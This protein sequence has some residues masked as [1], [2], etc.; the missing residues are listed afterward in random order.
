LNSPRSALTTRGR[1]SLERFLVSL[2]VL[3]GLMPRIAPA[4]DATPRWFSLPE[5]DAAETLERFAEQ[6]G[7]AVVF[8]VDEVRGLRTRAVEGQLTVADALARLTAGSGLHAKTDRPTAIVVKRDPAA[9]F[10]APSETIVSMKTD[11]NPSPIRRT[12]RSTI[13]VLSGLLALLLPALPAASAATTSTGSI[14]GR[15]MNVASGDFLSR[16]RVTV[17]G[18]AAE[19]YTDDRGEYRLT[20]VPAGR[21]EVRVNFTGFAEQARSVEVSSGQVVRADFR[22][23]APS[24][25]GTPATGEEVVQLDAFT[26]VD[27]ELTAQAVALHEQRSAPNIKSVVAADEFGDLGVT[28]PANF[29]AYMPGTAV[30]IAT[31]EAETVS[32]R[33]M[34]AGTT[35]VMMDGA[36]LAT[37]DFNSRQFSFSGTSAAVVERIEVTKVPTPDVPANAVGGSINMV[38][39]S[40]LS[41]TTPLLRYDVFV[42]AQGKGDVPRINGGFGKEEGPDGKSSA[43]FVRPGFDLNYLHPVNRHLALTFNLAY[44]SRSQDREYISPSWNRVQNFQTNGSLNSVLNIFVKSLVAAGA[45]YRIGDSTFTFRADFTQHDSITRQNLFTY[46]FGGGATGGEFFTRSAATA[47][48]MLGQTLGQNVNQYRKQVNLRAGHR[49]E[50]DRWKF[51]WNASYSMAQRDYSDVDEDMFGTVAI[52]YPNLVLEGQGLDAIYSMGIP[53]L[54][55]RTAAGVEVDPYDFSKYTLNTASSGRQF[56]QSTVKAAGA[57]V[58]RLFRGIVPLTVK[59]GAAVERMSRDAWTESLTWNIRPPAAAGGQV[60][61]NY[62]IMA[63]GYSARRQ[64]H[65]VPP[66][67]WVSAA[68][69]YDLYRAHPEYFQLNETTAHTGR[70][71]SSKLLYETISAGYLRADAKALNNRLWLVGGARYERTVDEGYGP[72]NDIRATFQRDANDN[73]VL[74][75]GRPVPITTDPVQSAKLQFQERA[76]HSKKRWDDI[77]PSLNTSFWLTDALVIRAAYAATMGRPDIA[78]IVPGTSITDPSAVSRTITVVNTGLEPWTADNYDLTLES[79]E[80]KGATVALSGF[81]KELT[82]FFKS[83]RLPASQELLERYSLPD[84]LLDGNYD[85]LFQENST[86]PGVVS[87]LEW[88]WRQSLR[89]FAKLPAFVRPVQFFANGTH[90]RLSGPGAASLAGYSPRVFNWGVGYVASRFSVKVNVS[91]S[92]GT[93][94]AISAPNNTTPAGTY[95]GVGPRTLASLAAEY[96]FH[97]AIT[98]HLSVQNLTNSLFQQF[99]YAPGSPV[100]TRP[101]VFRDNGV[102]YVLGVSGRF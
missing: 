83:V 76:A 51:D 81:R 24:T 17:A 38:S 16:A 6:A 101:N 94:G 57:S 27:K 13:P 96:R 32:L 40:G 99:T 4:A 89:P 84:D 23:A 20:S 65:G 5:G 77:F 37:N 93:R 70:V 55:A 41:R 29:L 19:A 14:E 26:V 33:G 64:F 47:G 74:N 53:R 21:A 66:I 43:P 8:F 30:G 59:T 22:L 35:I 2:A 79:Y 31:G 15:V 69:V 54:T 36:Q 71:N 7:I 102:D 75:N 82:N 67:T 73:L 60:V 56:H 86:E 45:D 10:D 90:L 78:F 12:S 72:L 91:K 42:T 49:Y 63:P 62:D 34:P 1:R 88:S 100:Y 68:K 87:G 11:P 18:T 58:S 28:N 95:T 85:I 46:N 3:L 98:V 48:G 61:G 97:P 92:D 52:A 9:A 44:N 39:R 80:W 50:G 25:R